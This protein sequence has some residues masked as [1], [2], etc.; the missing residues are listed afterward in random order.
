MYFHALCR[1]CP[2]LRAEKAALTKE[3]ERNWA[4]IEAQHCE[5]EKL[6]KSWTKGRNA[7]QEIDVKLKSIEDRL[8]KANKAIYEQKNETVRR[9]EILAD[10]A[11]EIGRF[12]A[13]IFEQNREI[14]ELRAKISTFEQRNREQVSMQYEPMGT[15]PR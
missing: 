11:K 6:E 7:A 1:N 10:R 2:V 5:V 13:Q 4:L 9:D 14:N 3:I 15:P 12:Q 8:E